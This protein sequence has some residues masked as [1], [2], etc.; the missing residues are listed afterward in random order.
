M[1]RYAPKG[2]VGMGNVALRRLICIP[3]NWGVIRCTPATRTLIANWRL[4]ASGGAEESATWAVKVNDPLWPVLPE[5]TPLAVSSWNPAGS[6]P[7]ARFHVYG[8]IPPD[9]DSACE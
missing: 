5:T 2:I 9:A 3:K 7:D 6:V 8:C 4:A 1:V